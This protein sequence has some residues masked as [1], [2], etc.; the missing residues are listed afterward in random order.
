MD[1]T[2]QIFR[3]LHFQNDVDAL[4]FK[5]SSFTFKQTRTLVES[6]KT[7]LNVSHLQK[8]D[9]SSF[10]KPLFTLKI[11]KDLKVLLTLEK[12]DIAPDYTLTLLR[13]VQLP[14]LQEAVETLDTEELCLPF[15]FEFNG[16][17]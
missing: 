17:W 3:S 16:F 13:V 4:T 6:L 10:E 14:H 5:E 12:N 7:G 11:Q 9:K 1:K 2:V 15:E 8:T